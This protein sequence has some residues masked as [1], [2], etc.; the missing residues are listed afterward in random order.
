MHPALQFIGVTALGVIVFFALFGAAFVLYEG[1]RAR[2]E[3]CILRQLAPGPS[4]GLD[5]VVN[6]DGILRRGTVYLHLSRLE[7]RGWIQSEQLPP[8]PP[9]TIGQRVYQLTPL[10]DADP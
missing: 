5:L 10:T 9:A 8:K 3:G 1:P 7:A 4:T 6:S 2:A